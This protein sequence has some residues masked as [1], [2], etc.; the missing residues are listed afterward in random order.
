MNHKEHYTRREGK[1]TWRS[2]GTT[3]AATYNPDGSLKRLDVYSTKPGETH[4]H[5]W[6]KQEPDGS[7]EFKSEKHDNHK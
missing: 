1:D 6:L 4:D 2:E 5:T 3:G 7:Y